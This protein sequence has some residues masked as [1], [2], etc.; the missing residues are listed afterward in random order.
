MFDK[1]LKP[2]PS[3]DL[4]VPAVIAPKP[5]VST[6]T[7][8]STTIDQDAPSIS[9]SQATQ[10]T[11][12]PVIPTSVEEAD[13]DIK[14]AHMD[15]TPSFDILIPEPNNVVGDPSRPVSTRNQ[16]Q[17]KALFYYFDDFLSSIEPKSYKDAL[18]ESSWIKAMQEELNG[19]ERLEV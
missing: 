10:K 7:P 5:A 6:G 15:N 18:T 14:V 17:D 12:S 8:S 13:H 2:P 3:I 1:Y 19:F 11:P 16:L 9:T 4:Q